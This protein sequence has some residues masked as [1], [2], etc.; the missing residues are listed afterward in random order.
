MLIR[1]T[2]V[3]IDMMVNQRVQLVSE[4]VNHHTKRPSLINSHRCGQSAAS[5]AP[6]SPP[7]GLAG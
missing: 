2:A 7:S 6:A 5:S 4:D 1:K 3:A